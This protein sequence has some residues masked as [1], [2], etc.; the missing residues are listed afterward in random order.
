MKTENPNYDLH[1]IS[2][3]VYCSICAFSGGGKTN[4]IANLLL[5]FGAKKGTFANVWIITRNKAESIYEWLESKTDRIIIKEGVANIPELDKMDKT[6][7]NCVIF[8]DLVLNKNQAAME[9][10]FI[11]ARKFNCSVFYLS[12]SWFKI[13][14]TIRSNSNLI[15][16]L[17]LSGNREINMILGEFGLGVTREQL[18]AMYQDATSEKMQP[19]IVD[20]LKEPKYRF[21]KGF[22]EYLDPD[23]YL[24]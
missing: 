15:I 9:Q 22:L 16:L 5:K 21:R 13:P 20:M 7:N 6:V 3:P 23:D 1:N 8:D 17:K 12:Q 4:F 10:Y 24:K 14:K 19:L 18:L 2:L 11:R